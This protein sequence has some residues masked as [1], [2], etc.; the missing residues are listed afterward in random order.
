VIGILTSDSAEKM[1]Q[2]SLMYKDTHAVSMLGLKL[3]LGLALSGAAHGVPL[4]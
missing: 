4:N 3:R 2:Y 1:R